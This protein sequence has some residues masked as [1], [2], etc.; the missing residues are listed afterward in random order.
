MLITAPKVNET[1]GKKRE[2]K[3][4]KDHLRIHSPRAQ[5]ASKTCT[6][7]NYSQLTCRGHVQCAIHKKREELLVDQ[8][9]PHL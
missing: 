6:F 1:F 3:K 7:K 2:K 4:K 8:T 5:Q 9:D